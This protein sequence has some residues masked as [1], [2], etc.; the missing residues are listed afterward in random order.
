MS[1]TY[2]TLKTAIQDY[3]ESS[4]TTFT[5]NLPV[6]IKEAEERILKNTQLSVFRKNVTG[7]GTS[8]NT[9]L[10]TPSDFLTSLSLAVLDSDSVYDFLMLKHVTFVREY[11]PTAATTGAPKYYAIFDENTFILAPTPSS[12]FTF[13]LHYI[14]RPESIT[15]SADGTS[16][17]GTNAPDAL[18]YGSL[19][20]AATFLKLDLPQIQ[21]FEARFVA[22]VGGVKGMLE[23]G[24]KNKD[25]FRYDS[26]IGAVPREQ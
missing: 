7:T 19:V 12:N 14:S 25:E 26:S 23:E 1:W 8:G 9:Y 15:A 4:E 10:A 20:E 24:I 6:F 22:A 3:V 16:W 11:I 2:T 18:F 5:T 13:E 17:M 21:M